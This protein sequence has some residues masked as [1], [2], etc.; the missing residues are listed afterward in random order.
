MDKLKQ[1]NYVQIVFILTGFVALVN[2]S[3][4]LATTSLVFAAYITVNKWMDAQK[5][6]DVSEDVRKEVADLKTYVS[7]LTMSRIKTSST[8][9][10]VRLF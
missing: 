8:G 1:L 2:A 10:N 5:A 6:L 4:A 9:D 3:F 7:G